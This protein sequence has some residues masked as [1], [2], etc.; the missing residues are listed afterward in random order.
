MSEKRDALV[1]KVKAR[2]DEWNAEIDRLQARAEQAEADARIEYHDEILKLKNYRDE[3]RKKL[4]KLQ[5]AGE[6]AWED[7]KAGVEMAFDAMNQAV[8]SARQRFK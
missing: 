8:H 5:H 3:A 6:G 4:D 7:L 1:Q 2:I